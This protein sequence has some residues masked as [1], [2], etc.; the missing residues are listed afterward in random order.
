MVKG[1][2]D[3]LHMFKMNMKSSLFND[4]LLCSFSLDH[5]FTKCCPS[6]GGQWSREEAA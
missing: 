1:N 4:N 2:L 5:I 3:K 6:S